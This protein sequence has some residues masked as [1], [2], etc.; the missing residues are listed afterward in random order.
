MRKVFDF[1]DR[2]KTETLPADKVFHV[3]G[4]TLGGD[5]GLSAIDFGR[6]TLGG[7]IAA[8]RVAADTF[9]NG[10]LQ[11]SGFMETGQHQAVARPAR[12][13]DRD[14][15]RLPWPGDARRDRA[16]GERTSSSRRCG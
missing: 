5:V 15:R 2:G 7:A 9:R 13:P 10:G 12:R 6:R 11:L 1:I 4:L 16:A 8:N 3:R 14:I